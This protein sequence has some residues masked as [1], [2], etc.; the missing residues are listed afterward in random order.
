MAFIKR[1]ST[2]S[3]PLFVNL[4]LATQ[5]KV[6][7]A[8]MGDVQAITGPGRLAVLFNTEQQDI[9]IWDFNGGSPG[10]SDLIA[11]FKLITEGPIQMRIG[12]VNGIR[13]NT[14]GKGII[15]HYTLD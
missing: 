10:D 15:I 14:Q 3:V 6:R 2:P 7:V 4:D 13:V 11:D 12:F 5:M 9:T 8:V 1:G